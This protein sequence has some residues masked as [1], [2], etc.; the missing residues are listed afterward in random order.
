MNQV[1]LMEQQTGV[2]IPGPEIYQMARQMY[3]ERLKLAK[4]EA[5]ERAKRMSEKIA[6][7]LAEGEWLESFAAFVHYLTTYQTAILKGPVGGYVA[8]K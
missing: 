5:K 8:G 7:Q 1:K 2:M 3:D 4:T 6:D